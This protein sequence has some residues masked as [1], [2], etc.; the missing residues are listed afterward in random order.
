MRQ[1]IYNMP[2]NYLNNYAARINAVTLNELN[3]AIKKHILLA[4]NFYVT[5]GPELTKK[6]L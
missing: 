6:E 4:D 2:Q 3:A 1:I 5:V